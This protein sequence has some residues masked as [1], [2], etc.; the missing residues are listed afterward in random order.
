MRIKDKV[1]VVTGAGSGIGLAIA[2][3][4][5]AEGAKVVA[6][7]WH[8][9]AISAAVAD[10][11]GSIVGMTG[12]VS[13][14]VDCVA[15]IERARTEFGRVDILVNNAGVMDLFQS[16]ADVDNATWRRCMAVNVDGPMYAMRRAVPLMLAQGSGA[17]VNIAS[18]AA[19]GGGA[20]G[21][22]YTASKH[23]LIGLT[24]STAYQ[25]AKLGL[26]CNALAVG[27]VSTNIMDSVE[28]RALDEAALG[29][30]GAYHASNP[31]ML[32]PEDI[33]NAVLFLASD[34]ARHLN[35]AVLPVDM[36]WSAA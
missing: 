1:A 34:E 26:R 27:G 19:T 8:A 22:A 12:D 36:G 21:A 29:R 3:R 31:G 18:V 20:A 23:A 6:L 10:I 17:I 14:E 2:R 7:D 16:V 24:R 9:N 30:M 35:G 11:G 15:M 5:V 25:Y 33:A 32:E 13:K 28:G 4:F